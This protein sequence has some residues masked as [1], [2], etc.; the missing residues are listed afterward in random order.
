[1]SAGLWTV[2]IDDAL[3]PERQYYPGERIIF[4]PPPGAYS[5]VSLQRK[6]AGQSATVRRMSGDDYLIAD[7]ESRH[8]VL[9]NAAFVEIEE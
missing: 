9:L 2:P 3:R 7:F 4:R 6:L 5:P 1:M 8:G